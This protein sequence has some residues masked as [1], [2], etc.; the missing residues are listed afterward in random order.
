[1]GTGVLSVQIS[2]ASDLFVYAHCTANADTGITLAFVNLSPNTTYSLDVTSLTSGK[3]VQVVP[4]QEYH[5][6]PL[7][8]SLCPRLPSVPIMCASL[9]MLRFQDGVVTSQVLQLNNATLTYG[10]PGKLDPAVPLTVTDASQPLLVAPISVGF[11]VLTAAT[12]M[13]T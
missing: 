1:M 12:N 8:R 9:T 7:V 10:G 11:I 6:T 4:R 3:P 13:C 5:L 2:G